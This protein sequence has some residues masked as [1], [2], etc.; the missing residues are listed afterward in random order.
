MAAKI[1]INALKLTKNHKQMR[2]KIGK[3]LK[4][5][6]LNSRLTGSKKEECSST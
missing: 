6:S 3:T 1:D 4:R 2:L 5:A